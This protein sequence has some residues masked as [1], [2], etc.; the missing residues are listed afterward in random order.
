[1]KEL[2]LTRSYFIILSWGTCLI[3]TVCHISGSVKLPAGVSIKS[4]E[5]INIFHIIFVSPYQVLSFSRKNYREKF[6]NYSR[7]MEVPAVHFYSI[8][9]KT[10]MYIRC[11][12]R[13]QE[14]CRPSWSTAMEIVSV[15]NSEY[16]CP[17]RNILRSKHNFESNSK[18]FWYG[19][20]ARKNWN[21][22]T[23]ILIRDLFP[24]RI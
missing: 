14:K 15:R 19:Q 5:I 3:S 13:H 17:I 22:M 23:N 21:G 11:T 6:E 8:N 18:I 16:I 4:L 7:L 2:L 1:M 9:T 10:V 24:K 12:S 20:I